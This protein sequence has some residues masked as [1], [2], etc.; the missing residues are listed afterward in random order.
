MLKT[1]EPNKKDD[2]LLS[3]LEFLDRNGF[4]QSFEKLQQKAGIYYEENNKKIIED[5]LHLREIDELILYIKNNSKIENE[6]KIGYIKLLKIKKYIDLII[7]NC[8]DRIDQKDSLNYL[9]TEIVP[10]INNN[11][12]KNK[13]L[14]NSL[15]NILFYKDMNLLTEYIRKNLN[16]YYDDSYIIKELSKNRIIQIEKLYNIYNNIKDNNK[17]SFDNY[18]TTSINDL[19][20]NPFKT[21][22]I[23]FLELSRNKKYIAL[24]FSNCNIS[25]ISVNVHKSKN[26]INLNLYLTFSSNENSRKGE[27]T[28]LCFSNDE[29]QL[30]VS[31]S[32][33]IVKIFSVNNG[34]KIKEYNNLH[35]SYIT[36][37]LYLP[38][39]NNKFLCGG[40]DKRLLLI[41]T[42]NIPFLEIGKF[43]RIKQILYSEFNNLIIII[44]ASINDII[45][46]NFPENKVSF[47]IEIKEETVYSNISKSDK[48]K[49]LL[50]NISKLYPKILLYNLEKIKTEDKFYGHIQRTMIIKCCF[51]GNKD[52]YILSGSEN[53][54]VYLWE[55]KYPGA[56]KYIFNGHLGIVNSVEFLFNDILLSVSDDKTL[57]IW[58]PDNKENNDNDNGS[59][60]DN[61]EKNKT[62]IFKKNEKNIYKY[63]ENNFE[64]EFFEKMNEALEEIQGEE[65]N[66]EESDEDEERNADNG[67]EGELE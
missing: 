6:E 59:E 46:Y 14:L 54:K 12:T 45:C 57:K 34:E 4:K 58:T 27:I 35:N 20:F 50:I 1:E 47:K 64:N 23:W 40:V 36:S 31:L 49:Y 67:L 53:A 13:N 24:G 28:S 33:Y 65:E 61:N 30:L 22:D 18:N 9:R 51:G 11:K 19:C 55:R 38:N 44:P 56:P 17:E 66:V 21:S 3:V 26:K 52:Q 62:I 37:C 29:K 41:D 2:L 60:N 48:G 15:T 32:T 5:L 25:L 7:K 16:I 10:M 42:N 8:S 39:S 43:C 63:I